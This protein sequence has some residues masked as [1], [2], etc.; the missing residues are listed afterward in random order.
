LSRDACLRWVVGFCFGICSAWPPVSLRRRLPGNPC[1]CPQSN[2]ATPLV[3][4]PQGAPAGGRKPPLRSSL[5]RTKGL[6]V[7]DLRGMFLPSAA[8]WP[9]CQ[10]LVKPEFPHRLRDPAL[11]NS[12]T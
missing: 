1:P 2:R 6:R 7:V 9:L 8:F 5:Q 12:F 3:A 11:T 10:P 4:A